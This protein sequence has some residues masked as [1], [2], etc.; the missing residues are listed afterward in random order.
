[1][2][3]KLGSVTSPFEVLFPDFTPPPPLWH[4]AIET[5]STARIRGAAHLNRFRIMMNRAPMADVNRQKKTWQRNLKVAD[6]PLFGVPFHPMEKNVNQ[7]WNELEDLVRLEPMK[8]VALAVGAGFVLC[9]LPLGRLLGF[10]VKLVF[11]LFKPALVILGA[12]KL[13]EYAR[14]RGSGG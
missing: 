11:L 5:T 2:N 10:L 12:V 7:P 8:A 6:G 1:M 3:E 14:Q 4:E 9:L 13:V